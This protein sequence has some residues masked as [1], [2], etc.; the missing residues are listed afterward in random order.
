MK[1]LEIII[2]VL[3][4]LLVVIP[5]VIAL[6]KFIQKAAKEKNWLEFV[7]LIIQLMAEAEKKFENGEDRH[8]WVIDNAE[9]GAKDINYDFDTKRVSKLIKSLCAMSKKVNISKE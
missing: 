7:L 8:N 2:E 3:D 4:V 9:I 5:L 1:W 6:I